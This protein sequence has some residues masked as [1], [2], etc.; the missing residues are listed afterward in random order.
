ME[1]LFKL[2]VRAHVILAV[3]VLSSYILEKVTG[4]ILIVTAFTEEKENRSMAEGNTGLFTI[5]YVIYQTGF[6][7]YNVHIRKNATPEYSFWKWLIIVVPLTIV[8][9][10]LYHRFQG[11]IVGYKDDR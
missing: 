7:I 2:F 5:L 4:L 3:I 8:F 1:Y 9:A 10:I 11:R 6:W